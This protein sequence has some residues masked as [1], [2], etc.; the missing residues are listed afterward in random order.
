MSLWGHGI[1]TASVLTAL[2]FIVSGLLCDNMVMAL[3]FLAANCA[4]AVDDQIEYNYNKRVSKCL[5]V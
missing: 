3:L 5:V 1:F 2:M 4:I